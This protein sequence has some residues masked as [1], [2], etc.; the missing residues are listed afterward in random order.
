MSEV[1]PEH[2]GMVADMHGLSASIN[3]LEEAVKIL[4]LKL[5]ILLQ[6]P[7]WMV[8]VAIS[9]MSGIIGVLGTF[10]LYVHF[11]VK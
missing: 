6:R 5:D 10:I 2:S 3:K 9:T 4:T 1:C 8:C 11:A 7:T